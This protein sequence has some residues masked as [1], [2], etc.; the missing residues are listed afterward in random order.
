MK[1]T[2]KRFFVATLALLLLLPVIT[3][4]G[5]AVEHN[6]SYAYVYDSYGEA[7]KSPSPYECAYRIDV[8]EYGMGA[9]RSGAGLFVRD[10]ELYI[11]DS[12]NNRILQL[13]FLTDGAEFVREITGTADGDL[14]GEIEE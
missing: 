3:M 1:K 8:S 2:M 7:Q 9:L 5:S 6:D 12:G 10:D 4:T 14:T 11:C 13:R